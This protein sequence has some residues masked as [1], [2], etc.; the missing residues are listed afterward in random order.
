MIYKCSDHQILSASQSIDIWNSFINTFK[1][2]YSNGI[3][4]NKLLSIR[5]FY[6]CLLIYTSLAHFLNYI[7]IDEFNS[8][9]CIKLIKELRF[10]IKESMDMHVI[11]WTII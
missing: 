7:V 1:W 6:H 8:Q 3:H 11:I 10:C 4:E 5:A 2:I 9:L